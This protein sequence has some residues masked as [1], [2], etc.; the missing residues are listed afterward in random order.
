MLLFS[1]CAQLF[2]ISWTVAKQAP[3]SSTISRNSLKFMCFDLV[4]LSNHLILCHLLLLSSMF[5]RIRVFSN[6]SALH[7]KWPKY[8]SFS[9]SSSNEYWGLISFSVDWFDLH[10]V[11][12]TLKV[13]PSTTVFKSVNSSVFSLL[14]GWTLTSIHD[15]WKNH[16]F[17]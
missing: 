4:I 12:Q 10:A 16:S 2:V 3:L 13:F 9:I 5:L 6:E 14:Y 15:Y 17:D 8:W 11:Q 1:C 7:I